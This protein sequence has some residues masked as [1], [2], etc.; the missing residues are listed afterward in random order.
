MEWK[1]LRG[2][3]KRRHQAQAA[4]GTCEAASCCCCV[5]AS[6]SKSSAT[7]PP[8]CQDAIAEQCLQG[9]ISMIGGDE[10]DREAEL[11]LCS[12][13][14]MSACVPWRGKSRS[15]PANSRA[16]G[17][18][19]P[20]P[21]PAGPLAAAGR[22]GVTGRTRG[23]QSGVCAALWYVEASSS[24]VSINDLVVLAFVRN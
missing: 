6:G 20:R 19:F 22:R 21:T 11:L 5:V 1:V 10:D 23:R 13:P 17:S 2:R 15:A 4:I 7:T 3:G 9:D 8:S 18:N 14:R 16:R 24:F 12:S